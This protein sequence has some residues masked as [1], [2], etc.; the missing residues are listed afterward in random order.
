[1]ADTIATLVAKLVGDNSGFAAMLADSERR[2]NSFGAKARTETR[3]VQGAFRSIETAAAGL[4]TALAAIGVSVGLSTLIRQASEFEQQLNII[5]ATSGATD[6][7]MRTLEASIRRTGLEF[8]VGARAAAAA[9]QE[10]QKSGVSLTDINEGALDSAV[11]LA[12]ALGGNYA[13]SASVAATA[14]QVFHENAS[15]LD[16]V[17]QGVT[18]TVLGGRFELSDYTQALQQ[19][20]GAAHAAGVSLEDFNA[21]LLLIQRNIGSSGSDSGT[22]FRTFLSRLVPQSAEAQAAMHA[23]GLE[24]FDQQGH[25]VG[26]AEAAQRIR[27]AFSGLSQEAQTRNYYTIFGVDAA[28]VAQALTNE[29]AAGVARYRTEV[30]SAANAADIATSRTQGFAGATANLKSSFEEL[31]VAIGESGIMD[32]MTAL[33]NWAAGGLQSA[34]RRTQ[35]FSAGMSLLA[36]ERQATDP[37]D[38]YIQRL[39][40][41][42]YRQASGDNFMLAP[43]AHEGLQAQRQAIMRDRALL[44]SMLNEGISQDDLMVWNHP[45]GRRYSDT[46]LGQKI[47]DLLDRTAPQREGHY[48]RGAMSDPASVQS[49]SGQTAAGGIDPYAAQLARQAE[50]AARDAAQ[51]AQRDADYQR[52]LAEIE[53]ELP[54][55]A[56]RFQRAMELGFSP[57]AIKQGLEGVGLKFDV[58]ALIGRDDELKAQAER[59]ADSLTN[60]I[61]NAFVTNDWSSF[62]EGAGQ[63]FRQALWDVFFGDE[64]NDLMH[65]GALILKNILTQVLGGD[66]GFGG[67]GGVFKTTPGTGTKGGAGQA[68]G[69]N[70]WI[71]TAINLFAG[72]FADGGQLQPGQWGIAGENG[73]EPIYAGKTGMTVIPHDAGG[74]RTT[75]VHMTVDVSGASG[76]E[77]VARIAEAAAARGARQAI[78]TVNRELPGMMS[79]ARER[80]YAA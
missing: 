65:K 7:Q 58:Q 36:N 51:Q 40:R 25:F 74:G 46:E 68:G 22:A 30:E 17:I 6:Q 47:R 70:S 41:E 11:T 59:A 52:W 31:G 14:M 67:W 66:G 42:R 57:D 69:Q 76:N 43:N 27:T 62:T 18:G 23:L 8:R 77:E 79:N 19:G 39:A 75:V 28:R 55:T 80:G 29:G 26:L 1:M 71:G 49:R 61:E 63:S 50:S 38:F 9:A 72:L 12:Q 3:A 2:M 73:P 44:D 13:D 10:L 34:A 45:D 21:A 33:T 4:G 16:K 37:L 56:K 5:R 64:V 35:D 24:F 54:E 20:G 53:R 32:V 60:S 48:S 78:S 15:D